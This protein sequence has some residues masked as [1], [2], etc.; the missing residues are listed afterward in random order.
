MIYRLGDS[1]DVSRPRWTKALAVALAL[2]VA[3]LN[4]AFGEARGAKPDGTKEKPTSKEAPRTKPDPL[5]DIMV[6]DMPWGKAMTE[7][8]AQGADL[9]PRALAM[10]GDDAQVVLAVRYRSYDHW[11]A[12]FGYWV[13]DP[14]QMLYGKPGGGLLVLGLG[15]GQRKVLLND[16]NGSV[17][18]PHVHYDG[19]TILF[20]YRKGGTR[21]YNLYEIQADGTGLRQITHGPFDDIEPIYLPNDEIVFISSRCNRWVPC[22]YTHVG[23]LYRCDRQGGRIRALS[24][25][26][27]HENTPWML[28]DGRVLYMRWEYNSRNVNLFHHLWAVNPDGTGAA[29]YYGN[30]HPNHVMIDAKPVPGT[31]D[32]ASI[33]SWGH[34]SEEHRGGLVLVSAQ[35]G[36]D[37]ASAVRVIGPGTAWRDPYPLA[38]DLFLVAKRGQLV[39]MDDRGRG[40]TLLSLPEKEPLSGDDSPVCYDP[41]AVKANHKRFHRAGCPHAV[42][43]L[44]RTTLKDAR[45]KGWVPCWLCEDGPW[46]NEPRPLRPRAREPIIPDRTDARA[47]TGRLV[48]TNVARGRNM[49]GV[50]PGEIKQLLVLEELP[51]P[52]SN[53]D[54]Q[55]MP[56]AL[57]L[58]RILGTV[59][60]EP[61]GS[62]NMEV[63]AM[64][65]LYFVALDA[66]QR[67]VKSMQS[68]VSVMPGE[69]VGCIGCHEYRT[70]SGLVPHSLA[71]TK[72]PPSRPHRPE[73][74]PDVFHFPRD[75]QPILDRHCV[76]CHGFDSPKP[77]AGGVA[78]NGDRTTAGHRNPGVFTH[79]YCALFARDQIVFDV[80]GLGN[81]PPRSLGTGASPLMSKI[82]GTHHKVTLSPE[83]RRMIHWWV[84]S[85]A[86]FAGTAAWN[87]REWQS[88]V[89]DLSK[90]DEVFRRR[91]CV[92][93]HRL[94]MDAADWRIGDSRFS[95]A[96][97]YNLTRP[98]KSRVLLAPLARGAGGWDVC[99]PVLK[100]AVGPT[101]PTVDAK[102]PPVFAAREDAD[103][104]TV[105]AALR[106]VRERLDRRTTPD[107]PNY[108]P[109]EQ[110]VREMKRYGILPATFD[111]ARDPINVFDVDAAYWRS[112]WPT[113]AM[114]PDRPAAA[115]AKQGQP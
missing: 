5:K 21:H 75:I 15:T 98:E 94:S 111:L 65:S 2:A 63:P 103:Y 4:G 67:A 100:G 54:R 43:R 37:D 17:R 83:E 3:V 51:Q 115:A 81:N 40:Q 62:A 35:R 59:P 95:T 93:C 8:L 12:N 32:V 90:A 16:P 101:P 107:M 22:W 105:L 89:S 24:T 45:D 7:T 48:L 18:D 91:R 30:M 77:P 79:G 68:F 80:E 73:G 39:V 6:G 36:P 106:A 114:Q 49:D 47:T 60:V 58:R 97:M 1:G 28:P 74:V 71:S 86:H 70:E 92:Q 84:D 34:G 96:G 52:Y 76:K 99:K 19:R 9:L 56:R 31:H 11:Y 26:V 13:N 42:P 78:L 29:A 82:D 108:R 88:L 10:L 50:K 25:N 57:T 41:N 113:P 112:F 109:D 55:G 64:R 23:I 69:T 102:A 85:D 33:F 14:E 110:Y 27:E 66:N 20:S 104:Q 87:A 38:S 72:R 44:V 61:D 46:V 53:N